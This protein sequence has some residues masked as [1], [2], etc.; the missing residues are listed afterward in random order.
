MSKYRQHTTEQ[1][2]KSRVNFVEF[3]NQGY[4]EI[5]RKQAEKIHEMA[6][7][8]DKAATIEEERTLKD[9]EIMSR[10]KTENKVIVFNLIFIT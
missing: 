5:I 1:I 9:E 8:M 6:I 7:F 3:Q 4:N 2:Y 10:L